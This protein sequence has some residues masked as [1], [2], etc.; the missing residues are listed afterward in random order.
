MK[1]LARG[2]HSSLFVG[3][4]GDEEISFVSL[5][6]TISLFFAITVKRAENVYTQRNYI[7]LFEAQVTVLHN[8]LECFTM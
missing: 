6:P 7:K 2:K 8:K 5:T 3:N 4:G 1:F